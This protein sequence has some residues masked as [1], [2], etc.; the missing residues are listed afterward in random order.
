MK[1]KSLSIYVWSTWKALRDYQ[2][3]E[4]LNKKGAKNV[5]VWQKENISDSWKDLPSHNKKN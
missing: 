1:E 2:E 3:K 5:T 4:Q